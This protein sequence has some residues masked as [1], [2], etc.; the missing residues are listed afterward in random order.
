MMEARW[1]WGMA[2]VSPLGTMIKTWGAEGCPVRVWV[3]LGKSPSFHCFTSLIYNEGKNNFA[4]YFTLALHAHFI[5]LRSSLCNPRRKGI[6]TKK[7]MIIT[8]HIVFICNLHFR[9]HYF[10][11]QYFIMEE[12]DM[13]SFCLMEVNSDLILPRSWIFNTVEQYADIP[14]LLL[15][16]LCCT[17]S[18]MFP[19]P[20]RKM[21]RSCSEFSVGWQYFVI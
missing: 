7:K 17:S 10:W 20:G 21:E 14:R 18:A 3:W 16:P 1:R 2:L 9:I 6:I 11:C 13:L 4:V 19:W 15:L 12:W 8:K 5:T